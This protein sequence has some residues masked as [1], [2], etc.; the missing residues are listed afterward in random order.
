VLGGEAVIA[1]VGPRL[2][3][4]QP[5]TRPQMAHHHALNFSRAWSLFAIYEA[6]HQEK[7]LEVYLDHMQDT[8]A[9]PAWWRGD[10]RAVAHWVPQF[11]LFALQRAMQRGL[12]SGGAGAFACA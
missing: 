12:S 10:Y 9:R 11:G 6:T 8:L 3:A 5:V 1:K 7:L 2:L 4:L